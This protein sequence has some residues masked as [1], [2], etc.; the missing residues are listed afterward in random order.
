MT[1]ITNCSIC[2]SKLEE[3]ETRGYLIPNLRKKKQEDILASHQ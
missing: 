2:D 1:E 3:E